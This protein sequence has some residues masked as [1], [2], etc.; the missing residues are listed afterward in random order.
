MIGCDGEDIL[1]LFLEFLKDP[2]SEIV[3]NKSR[4]IKEL[5]KAKQKLANLSRDPNTRD[6]FNA[7]E[8][9]LKD[10]NS[11]F[12]NAELRGEIRGKLEVAK[13]LLGKLQDS[14]IATITGLSLEQIKE[15]R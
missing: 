10:K 8:K 4:E 7:R 2:Y 6:Q 5:S 9:A 3:E 15:L 1:Q 14:E 13:N 11:A 12:Y